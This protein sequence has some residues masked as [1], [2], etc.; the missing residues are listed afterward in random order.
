MGTY[1]INNQITNLEDFKKYLE[2]NINSSLSINNFVKDITY[3]IKIGEISDFLL[4]YVYYLFKAKHNVL[5]GGLF[6]TLDWVEEFLIPKLEL[7]SD[8][9]FFCLYYGNFF[10]VKNKEDLIKFIESQYDQ[11]WSTPSFII[12]LSEVFGLSYG[13]DMHASYCTH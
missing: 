12:G 8:Q 13:G 5:T 10:I 7:L 1:S 9:E 3:K 4:T 2:E 6:D 11:N